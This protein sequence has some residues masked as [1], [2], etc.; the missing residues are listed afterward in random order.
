MGAG[1]P[2]LLGAK[3]PGDVASRPAALIDGVWPPG[4]ANPQCPIAIPAP[5]QGLL[6]EVWYSGKTQKPE[7]GS[8]ATP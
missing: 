7:T 2:A 3:A 8:R 4:R 6:Q 1:E 5:K